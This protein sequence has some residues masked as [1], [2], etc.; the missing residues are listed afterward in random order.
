M[1]YYTKD[2][3][4]GKLSDEEIEKMDQKYNFYINKIY[5]KLPFTIKLLAK[6][7]NLHDGIVKKIKLS[8]RINV[9]F[10]EGIFGDLQT[11]YFSME[12]KYIDIK[13]IDSTTFA[14]LKDKK[15]EIL[16]HEFEAVSDKRYVHRMIFSP[17]DELE[18]VFSDISINIQNL[19]PTAYKKSECSFDVL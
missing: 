3:C 6:E 4:F 7:I 13:E 10:L 14:G 12:I 8:P 18:I 11:G 1:K 2:W 9:L 17:G 5:S 15:I 16:S 19:E